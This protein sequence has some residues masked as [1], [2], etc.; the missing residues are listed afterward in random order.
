MKF[1]CCLN[2]VF[3]FKKLH[4][5]T[6]FVYVTLLYFTSLPLSEHFVHVNVISVFAKDN[7]IAF[8]CTEMADTHECGTYI[9]YVTLLYLKALPL[10]EHCVHV[11][12]ISVFAKDDFLA[13]SCTE[14]AYTHECIRV[15]VSFHSINVFFGDIFN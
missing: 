3:N 14:M 9:V 4:C 6:Y 2:M 5:G 13:F 12:V 15:S 1:T 7:F 8:S 11:N 10:S